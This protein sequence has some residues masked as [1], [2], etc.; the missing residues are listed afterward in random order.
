MA[1]ADT[2]HRP[3]IVC[4]GPVERL[5]V[6]EFKHVPLHKRLPNFLISPSDEELVIMI[7]LLRQSRRKINW[8]LQVHSFPGEKGNSF[9]KSINLCSLQSCSVRTL[10]STSYKS[11]LGQ[12]YI[13][14]H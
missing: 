4:E 1:F 8:S 13:A 6:F 3:R 11:V 12:C 9:S 14:M 2:Y 10:H 5:D 7:G